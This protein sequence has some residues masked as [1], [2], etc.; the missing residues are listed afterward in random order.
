MAHDRVQIAFAHQDSDALA[1]L[2]VNGS[3]EQWEGLYSDVLQP[4]KCRIPEYAF[5]ANTH[6]F[7]DKVGSKASPAKQADKQPEA[8]KASDDALIHVAGL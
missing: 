8:E 7:L 5:A 1:R 6:S 2:W 4:K 3:F